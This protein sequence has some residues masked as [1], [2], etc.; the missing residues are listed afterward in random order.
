MANVTECIE[1]LATGGRD[2]ASSFVCLVIC[3]LPAD[4]TMPALEM[5]PAN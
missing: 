5:E 1:K 3:A 2:C 4:S